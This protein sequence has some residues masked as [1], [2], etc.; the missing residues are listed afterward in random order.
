MPPYHVPHAAAYPVEYKAT[1]M[2]SPMCMVTSPQRDPWKHSTG[3]NVVVAVEEV[4][5][6]K[7]WVEDVDV[8]TVAVLD[9]DVEV[10][11]VRVDDVDVVTVDVWDEEVWV[12]DV[13]VVFVSDDEVEVVRVLVDDV[14]VVAVFVVVVAVE[15][16][17]VRVV[18]LEVVE[19][20]VVHH[21]AVPSGANVGQDCT[22]PSSF[23]AAK[24]LSDSTPE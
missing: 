16:E 10:V 7:V 13:E 12:E 5:V 15:D 19:V 18:M 11:F 20:V 9:E 6:V 21:K 24:D 4:E 2:P 8:V 3:V 17:D 22:V 1:A 14:E 23:T